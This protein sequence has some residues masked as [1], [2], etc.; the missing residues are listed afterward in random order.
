[1]V[2]RHR[3]TEKYLRTLD[4]GPNLLRVW[5][6]GIRG[7]YFQLCPSGS[8]VFYLWYRWLRVAQDYRLG[9]Y[10][11]ITTTQSH[12]L[13]KIAAGDVA[14]G[15]DVHTKRELPAPAKYSARSTTRNIGQRR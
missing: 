9:A 4:P 12:S 8:R 5:D 2:D 14:R 1:M 15:T 3:L 6:M 7:F 10:A 11:A 13:A